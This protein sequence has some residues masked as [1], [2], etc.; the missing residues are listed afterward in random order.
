VQLTLLLLWPLSFASTHDRQAL[1]PCKDRQPDV[2]SPPPFRLLQDAA[3]FWPTAPKGLRVVPDEVQDCFNWYAKVGGL[4][5]RSAYET[6]PYLPS[7]PVCVQPW[8]LVTSRAVFSLW[9]LCADLQLQLRPTT[10]TPRSPSTRTPPLPA[11]RRR[12]L[13][14]SLSYTAR[15]RVGVLLHAVRQAR[16]SRERYKGGGGEGSVDVC[17]AVARDYRLKFTAGRRFGASNVSRFQ[18]ERLPSKHS[19]WSTCRKSANKR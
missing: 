18:A 17:V 16:R 5:V 7:S 15:A 6:D 9:A 13:P 19:R 8:S 3:S 11:G 12:S 2:F 1:R 4:K 10:D 14:A